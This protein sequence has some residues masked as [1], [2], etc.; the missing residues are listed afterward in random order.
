MEDDPRKWLS[1]K[2]VRNHARFYFS[3]AELGHPKQK[4]EKKRDSFK[5]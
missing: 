5:Y 3:A 4:S 2:W 1:K